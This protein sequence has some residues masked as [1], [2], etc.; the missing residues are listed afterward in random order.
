METETSRST[1]K[2]TSYEHNGLNQI[3]TE[4][5]T[6]KQKNT[7]SAPHGIFSKTDHIIAHK[8]KPQQIQED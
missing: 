8:T 5:F 4:H 1:R 3:S 6:L 2:L 7:F